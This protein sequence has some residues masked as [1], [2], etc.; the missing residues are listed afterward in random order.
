MGHHRKRRLEPPSGEQ[1]SEWMATTHE[2]FTLERKK[3]PV[4]KLQEKYQEHSDQVQQQ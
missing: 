4:S 1:A 2:A 3:E